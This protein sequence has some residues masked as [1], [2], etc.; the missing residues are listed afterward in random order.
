MA[1]TIR[2]RIK[3]RSHEQ[4]TKIIATLGPSVSSKDKL[5]ELITE[6]V[7]V[8]R[9]NFSHG[10]HK[11]HQQLIQYIRELNE[12]MK[13]SLCI[14]QDLQG[15]KLRLRKIKGGQVHLEAGKKLRITTKNIV[16]DD[17][18]LST[19]YDQLP[20]E[21]HANQVILLNDGNIELRIV[22]RLDQQTLLTEIIHGGLIKSH[23][24]LNLPETATILNSMTKKD[25]KDLKF[26]I[27]MGVDWIALSFVRY[28]R[29]VHQLRE[30]IHSYGFKT[31]IIA[32]IER[33]E[34]LNNLDE[35]IQASDAIMV[36]RGD[37][38]VEIPAEKVPIAQKR[39]VS[40]CNRMGR[41]VII[42]THMLE[43]MTRATR[44]TR[45]EA[46]DV[47]NAVM[48]GADA[49][50]LSAETATG[51]YPT[52]A[53][54]MMRRILHNVENEFSNN[55]ALYERTDLELSSNSSRY[56]SDSL[57][58]TACRL[59]K[60]IEARAIVALTQSG[61]VGFRLASFRPET[62]IL[63]FSSDLSTIGALN[64]VWGVRAFF[65]D[66]AKSTDE[67][68]IEIEERLCQAGIF[69]QGDVFVILTSMPVTA[70]SV[71]NTIKVNV[72]SSS[73]KRKM[74]L[75][76]GQSLPKH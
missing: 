67:T 14:L 5:R 59:R 44:P 56:I 62:D 1:H 75:E 74:A 25:E 7:S 35:I 69:S 54:R 70:K 72:V 63:V 6:G 45:S 43:S 52:Y 12:S 39:I 76:K 23:Q 36:A 31:K 27:K 50:M 29:D 20:V 40:T 9:L 18:E 21:A 42:A 13:A 64:L 4:K 41:P 17:K 37:L 71:T 46:T 11:E 34:A 48:D 73:Q 58:C 3:L 33:P 15:P 28:A 22:E 61:Y 2:Q 24:G 26:G 38:G 51:D 19:D 60:Q 55:K 49:V 10:T 68:I 8:V 16:G 47:T 32:K 53:V 57:I 30:L 65:Y 66:S